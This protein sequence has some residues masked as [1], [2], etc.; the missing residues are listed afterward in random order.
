[1]DRIKELLL[2]KGKEYRRNKFNMTPK[3]KLRSLEKKMERLQ[4]WY[5]DFDLKHASRHITGITKYH[6]LERECFYLKF[7]IEHCQTC[8]K[9]LKN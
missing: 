5:P 4:K 9:K 6:E 2:V 1:M 7:E 8:G 3:Q